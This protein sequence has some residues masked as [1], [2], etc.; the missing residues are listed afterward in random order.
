MEIFKIAVTGSVGSGKTTFINTVS[1]IETLD[2]SHE[3]TQ[4][5][6]RFSSIIAPGFD[7]GRITFNSQQMMYLYGTRGEMV[8]DSRWDTVFERVDAY[9]M[10]IDAHRPEEF[11]RCRRMFN[12]L[13]Q[14]FALPAIVGLTNLDS[15]V[16]WQPDNIAL[17]MRIR[18][19]QALCSLVSVNPKDTSSVARCLISLVKSTLAISVAS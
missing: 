7:F 5:N 1:E 18:H 4:Q 19:S 15:E 16:A 8:C 3:S 6:E 14:R 12:F 9:V 17:V 10:L 11:I 13:Q 2:R